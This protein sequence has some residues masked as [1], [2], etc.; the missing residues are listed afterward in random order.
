RS[1]TATEALDV[2]VGLLEAHGQG[3]S[4]HVHLDWPY[5]NGFLI[6]DPTSAWILETSDRHWAARRVHDVGNVSNGLALA[7]DWERGAADL[8]SFAV[9]RGWWTAERGR[10]DFAAAYADD[11]GVPPNLCAERRRRAATL[12]DGLRG[13]ASAATLRAVLRDHYDAGP[14]SRP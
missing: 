10:L 6:A 8:T 4:G 5:H 13:R 12:L 11:G 1:R 9:D 7:A 2:I 3:G 14:A